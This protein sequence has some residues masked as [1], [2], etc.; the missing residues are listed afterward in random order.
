MASYESV[1][2]EAVT[3]LMEKRISSAALDVSMLMTAA[4]GQSRLALFTAEMDEM[5]EEELEAFQALMARRLQGEPVAYILGEKEF[6]GLPFKVEPGVL[7]PRPD[8]ETLVGA[9]VAFVGSKEA[10]A[11]VAD[12]GTGSGALIVSILHEFKNFK[13][14]GVDISPKAL[15]ITRYN[16]EKNGVAERLTMLEGSYLSPLKEQGQQVDIL[17][18]NPPYI[19]TEV[20]NTLQTDVKDFEPHLALDGGTDGLVAY[21]SII[22]QAEETVRGGG[23]IMLEIGFDQKDAI[24]PLFDTDKWSD[25]QCFKD[26]GGNDRVIVALRRE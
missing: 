4:T 15:D 11:T 25:I 16:A 3:K 20:I 24:I 5:K 6:W 2:R 21:K 13:G 18:S 12:I 10:E 7:I 17:V 22:P 9:L 26:L 19:Q 23:L 14:F 8:T 1:S